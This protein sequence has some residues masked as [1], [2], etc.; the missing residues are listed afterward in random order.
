MEFYICKV[1]KHESCPQYHI[2]FWPGGE[3]RRCI[4]CICA[5]HE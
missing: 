5:C 4:S 3:L 1:G 2:E